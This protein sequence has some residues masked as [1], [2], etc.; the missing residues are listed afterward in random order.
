MTEQIDTSRPA[1]ASVPRSRRPR[2]RVRLGA[3]VAVLLLA[4]L[5]V[6]LV[7]RGVEPTPE[8]VSTAAK[9]VAVSAAG[10]ATLAGAVDSPIYWAGPKTGYTYELTKAASGRVFVRYLPKGVPAG[11]DELY[12]TI[13]TYPFKGAF[14]ATRSLA[15]R[16]DAV[17]IPIGGGGIAFYSNAIPTSIYVAFPNS[18][19]QIEVYDPSP[20]AARQLLA[21]GR[22]TPVVEAST[23]S[24]VR[25]VT[26]A[27][28]KTFAKSFVHAV[29]WVG[30]RDATTYE[31]SETAGGNV[32]V[33]YLPSGATIG[34]AK[35]YLTVGTYVVP[36]AFATTESQSRAPG[37]VAL[38]VHKG[39]A[40]AFYQGSTPTN[41]Y[42]AYPDE[43][44]Q[45]EVYDP[46]P[47]R[48]RALVTSGSVKPIG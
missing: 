14:S 24:G 32:F 5:V 23:S 41:T 19:Y 21:S 12:L 44:V 16:P 47:A 38:N 18:D 6:W 11:V 48:A 9:P 33:R 13:G 27:E 42:L 28:L 1:R 17:K 26:P 8:P 31:L 4:G 20:A 15:N 36:N 34:T 25:A 45:I 29:Y 2:P 10:L 22:L 40:V 35:P 46:S 30:V 39:T 3:I 37:A 7:A 43:D